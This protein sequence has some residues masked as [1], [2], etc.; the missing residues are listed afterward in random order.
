MQDFFIRF[1]VNHIKIADE[2]WVVSEGAGENLRSLGYTGDYIVMPN[3]VDFPRGRVDTAAITAQYHIQDDVPVLLFVGRM[4]W[5]KNLRLMLDALRIYKESGHSFRMFM[6]GKGTDMRAAEKYAAKIG[7]AKDITFTGK[8]SDRDELRAFYSRADAFLFPSTFDTNGLVVRE[9]AAC[10]CPSLLI[11]GSCAA[12][13]IEEGVTG[14][15]SE[16]NASAYAKALERMLSDPEKM[17]QVGENAS[18]EIYLSWEDAVR[19][20]YARYESLCRNWKYPEGYHDE[21]WGKE[22]DTEQ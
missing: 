6:I 3:G 7:L 16:E 12:E 17:R 4:M 18:K 11:A 15:L 14:Y 5:Y 20:A 2:V 22:E 19:M 21:S 13:G 10:G 9:A 1:I 8:M